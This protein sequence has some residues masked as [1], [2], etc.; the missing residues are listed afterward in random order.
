MN[1]EGHLVRV[2]DAA[3]IQALLALDPDYWLE[4]EGTPLRDDEGVHLLAERPPGVP[5]ER[6]YAVIVD[7]VALL[8]FSEGYPDAH[9]W[10]LGLIFLA[11]AV[12]GR[13]LGSALI[14]ALADHVRAHGGR[15]LRLAVAGDNPNARR[16]YDRLGFRFVRPHTRTLHTG[17]TIELDVLELTV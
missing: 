8:D 14:R 3:A 1:V 9:T 17:A 16:L 7:D 13:G 12:R 6:K 10:F 15:A 5:A 4:V 2:A 11:P